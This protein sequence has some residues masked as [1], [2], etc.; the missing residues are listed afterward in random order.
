MWENFL[1]LEVLIIFKK[2]KNLIKT[3]Q[4]KL[5]ITM[6]SDRFIKSFSNQKLKL[7]KILIELLINIW[8][9][10][11]WMNRFFI[12]VKHILIILIH[13]SNESYITFLSYLFLLNFLYEMIAQIYYSWKWILKVCVKADTSVSFFRE[14]FNVCLYFSIKSINILNQY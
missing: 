1:E 4:V 8:R 6:L 12:L 13:A 7:T 14:Y 9:N 5:S 10:N 3:M 11:E 2:K